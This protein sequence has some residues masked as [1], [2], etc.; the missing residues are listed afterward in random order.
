MS[1]GAPGERRAGPEAPLARWAR[2]GVH[3]GIAALAL[4]LL[5][6]VLRTE[7][8]RLWPDRGYPLLVVAFALATAIPAALRA[9]KAPAVWDENLL[10]RLDGSQK[11]RFALFAAI[12]IAYAASFGAAGFLLVTTLAL[13]ASGWAL[14]RAR[15]LIVAPI[16]ALFTLAVWLLFQRAL[17]VSLPG[18]PLERALSEALGKL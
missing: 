15:P 10:A 8:V 6:D 7:G 1:A 16:S 18:G 11:R 17:Y 3:L 13:T 4:V 5:R 2:V 9:L 14:E 12:W